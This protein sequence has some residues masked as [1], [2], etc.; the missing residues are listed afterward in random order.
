[1]YFRYLQLIGRARTAHTHFYVC[2]IARRRSA[3]IAGA[4]YDFSFFISISGQDILFV[5]YSLA[6]QAVTCVG[7]TCVEVTC[8]EV[9]CVGVTCVRVHSW[10]MYPLH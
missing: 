4:V 8:V 2:A 3:G 9:T 7:V 1:M 10:D 5:H 6:N